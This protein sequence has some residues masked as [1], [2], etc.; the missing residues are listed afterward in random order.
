MANLR[1]TL[2]LV[3]STDKIERQRAILQSEYQRLN[4]IADSKELARYNELHAF[5]NS[6]EFAD[7]K[8]QIQGQKF[9]D[10]E[11]YSKEQRF[12]TLKKDKS[13][14]DYYKIAGSSDLAE[15]R[16]I[17][18]SQDLKRYYELEEFI[19]SKEFEDVKNYMDLP[20]RKKFEQSNEYNA[21]TNYNNLKN[22]PDLQAYIKLQ[23]KNGFNDFLKV[24][25]TDKAAEF[26]DLKKK[27]ESPGFKAKLSSI[28]KKERSTSEEYREFEKYKALKKDP[29]IKNYQKIKNSNLFGS[30]EKMHE[31]P[32]LEAYREL[33]A[34]V[35]SPEFK[36]T[37]K[38]IESQKFKDT[39]ASRKLNEYK[40][41]KKSKPISFYF[42]FK[43]SALYKNYLQLDGSEKIKEY[44]ELKDFIA[45]EEFKKVKEYMNL[46]SG[47]KFNMSEEKKMLYEYQSLKKSDN[48]KYYFKYK[49]SKK[50]EELRTWEV[51]FEEDFA[52]STINPEKW[53]KKYYWGDKLLNDTYSLATDKHLI[54]EDNVNVKNSILEIVTR[55]EDVKGKAWEP[56]IGFYEKDFHFTSGL[57]NT[58]KS[59]RQK[60][61]KFEAKIRFNQDF[62]VNHAFWMVSDKQVPHVDIVKYDKHLNFNNFWKNG[63]PSI[64]QNLNKVK[65]SKYP[66]D[67]FI[68]G[69]EWTPEQLTWTINGITVATQTAGVPQE[70]MYIQFSSGL[71]EESELMQPAKCEIDW[72]RCYKQKDK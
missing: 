4:D 14:K 31:S 71:Y 67:F 13:I 36:K 41:L 59:F 11:E 62:P 16:R 68:Y 22:N 33:D 12:L 19:Q 45:S 64:H 38:T 37:K 65:S 69:L 61:G 52:T 40:R 2:G 24:Y 23:K 9:S 29:Q 47:K 26:D 51:S 21:L 72:I 8:K 27:I 30:F 44:E 7:R 50:F 42:K 10:T 5:L 39:E 25:G 35:N 54:S 28:P 15:F 53:L 17:Q 58:G 6:P 32:E 66:K 3:P 70:P 60:F 1:I 55:K 20:A 49:D 57:V 18:N 48:I 43:E 34:Y 46:S 56:A 63:S